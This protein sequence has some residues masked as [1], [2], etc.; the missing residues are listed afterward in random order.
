MDAMESMKKLDEERT[1]LDKAGKQLEFNLK[2]IIVV[3]RFK[4]SG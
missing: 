2:V 3:F 1:N 4:T